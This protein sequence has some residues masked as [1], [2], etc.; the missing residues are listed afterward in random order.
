MKKNIL[1]V[2]CV[3]VMGCEVAVDELP[4]SGESAFEVAKAG[5][6]N[7]V[8]PTIKEKEKGK[9]LE[10]A[11][12]AKVKVKACNIP[13]RL[14]SNLEVGEEVC[15]KVVCVDFTYLVCP[16]GITEPLEPNH[17]DSCH[18]IIGQTDTTAG[19]KEEDKKQ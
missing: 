13:D 16:P 5:N 9:D 19:T 17:T 7:I 12:N 4:Q 14:C 1:F 11:T 18:W 15:T 6:P 8:V 3:M 10:I 2:L